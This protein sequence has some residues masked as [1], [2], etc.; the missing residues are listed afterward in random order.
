MVRKRKQTLPRIS[1]RERK[2]QLAVEEE[3]VR[4]SLAYA[5]KYL[6]L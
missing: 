1:G 4:K 6:E 5:R 3:N 2:E